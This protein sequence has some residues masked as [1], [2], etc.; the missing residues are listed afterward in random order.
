MKVSQRLFNM[1]PKLSV[2]NK[3]RLKVLNKIGDYMGRPFENRL[4][5]GATAIATQPFIDEHNKRVD[6][7]TA[8]ASRNRTIGKIIAGTAVGCVVRSAVYNLI[9]KTTSEDISVDRWD[10]F[11]TP[12]G[13]SKVSPHLQ[14][15]RLRNYRT[16]AA[17]IIAMFVMVGTNILFDVPLTTKISNYLNKR[18]AK[19]K[20]HINNTNNS[21]PKNDNKIPIKDRIKDKFNISSGGVL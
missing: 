7:D 15:N 9:Q 5:L 1:L 3:E 11:L 19:K 10:N 14:K 16:V 8:R 12:R 4:I 17:T 2:N 6:K 21:L 13:S 20:G 18:D